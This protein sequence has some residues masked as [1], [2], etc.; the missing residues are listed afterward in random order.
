MDER[1]FVEALFAALPEAFEDRE[2]YFDEDGALAYAA[3]GDA[4]MWLEDNAIRVRLVP[5]W[6]AS[7]RPGREDLVR[8]FWD[9]VEQQAAASAG[10][11]D[12]ETLLSL[13]CFEGVAWVDDLDEYLGPSTRA[14]RR[15]A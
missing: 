10:E 7:V 8:R 6:R 14:L 15:S 13:E 1:A 3:L 9:F 2:H 11:A 5:R 12:L 4:R